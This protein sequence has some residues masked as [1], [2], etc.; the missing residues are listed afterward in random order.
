MKKTKIVCTIG[1]ASEK[2]ETMLKLINN[3]M[4][5]MRMNFSHGD[6][7]E[8]GARIKTV[9]EINKELGTNIGIML[10]TR[11]PEIRT[12][13]LKD[14]KKVQI[15]QG[16]KIRVTM[17]YEYLG[18][19]EKIAISYPGLYDDIHIGGKILIED[20]NLSLTVLEK[21]EKNKEL[22]CV[23]NNTRLLGQKK[24]CNVPGVILNM[25]YVSKKDYDDIVFGC[26]QDIDFIAAS[27]VRRAQ[28]IL[29]IRKILEEQGKP[30]IKIISKIENQ[31][32]VDNMLE[33]IELSDGVMV[34]RGDLGVDVPAWTVPSIQE[35]MIREAQSQGKIVI[36]ATQMLDSMI[37][38]PRP[39]RAEV[40]DVY[41]SVLQGTGATMLSGESANGDFPDLAVDYMAKI[42][43]E[44]EENLDYL[45]LMD[46]ALEYEMN[47][48]SKPAIAYAASKLA[49]EF[50]A[51]AIVLDG[52]MNFAYEVSRYRPA[53]NVF[54]TVNSVKEARFLS[55]AWGVEP[56][57]GNAK[58]CL[59]VATKKLD[60]QK[61]DVVIYVTKST[62]EFKTIE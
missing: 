36:T 8:Q 29:D 56:V 39:T 7:V 58:K 11:G 24:N 19:S 53:C 18:D 13:Y 1:P 12:G 57:I 47:I 46:R 15:E 3:G 23:A 16:Q 6:Q 27:F 2:K 33:I 40:S 51:S 21:D 28:D 26:K 30:E 14:G 38:N 45:E 54:A 59:E 4:N 25:E 32:G 50:G 10:D 61:G 20:G 60:L 17:D 34:A 52:D 49:F 31:E 55:L 41:N 42:D 5:V 43:V 62:L 9:N 22:I 48:D 35:E 37:V 44:A